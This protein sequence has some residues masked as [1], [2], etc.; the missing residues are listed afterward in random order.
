MTLLLNVIMVSMM[1]LNASTKVSVTTQINVINSNGYIHL[2]L[3][4]MVGLQYEDSVD[5]ANIS[6][7]FNKGS[8]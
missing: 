4:C 3:F 1:Q 2:I 7:N 5:K 6:E 8:F